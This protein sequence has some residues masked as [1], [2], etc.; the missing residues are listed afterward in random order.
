VIVACPVLG[1]L[2]PP[3]F[4]YAILVKRKTALKPHNDSETAGKIY[5]PDVFG[6]TCLSRARAATKASIR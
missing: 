6:S 3:R 5:E 2:L 1:G 4:E